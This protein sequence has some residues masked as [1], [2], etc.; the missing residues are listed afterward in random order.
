MKVKRED[1]II[2]T[3]IQ[4]VKSKEDKRFKIEHG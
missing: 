4:P 2:E 3:S 1:E